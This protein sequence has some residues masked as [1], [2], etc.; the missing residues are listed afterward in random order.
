M[1]KKFAVGDKVVYQDEFCEVV[2]VNKNGT[3]NLID[4][5]ASEDD[6]PYKN[7]KLEDLDEMEDDDFEGELEVDDEEEEDEIPSPSDIIHTFLATEIA[8]EDL[9]LMAKY[10]E[11]KV[12]KKSTVHDMADEIIEWVVEDIL[13]YMNNT[14]DYD[15][16][17]TILDAFKKFI[18]ENNVSDMF[19]EFMPK[20]KKKS[21]GGS[22]K[23]WETEDAVISQTDA[24][25]FRLYEE[26]GKLQVFKKVEKSPTGVGKGVTIDTAEMTEEEAIRMMNVMAQSVK[27]QNF[28]D[29]FQ[30]IVEMLEE[31]TAELDAPK[32]PAKTSKK[33]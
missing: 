12:T 7:I 2:K 8:I 5:N 10:F 11:Y 16:K 19:K 17:A 25:E 29:R 24:N 4:L 28:E 1:A 6:M 21:Y 3:Y 9:R 14:K 32:K 33:R 15:E 13:D 18:E 20:N 30:Q 27:H 22:N 26:A 23:Y 31:M